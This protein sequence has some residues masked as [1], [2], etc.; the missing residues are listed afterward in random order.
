MPT[1]RTIEES[2][3]YSQQLDELGNIQYMDEALEGVVWALAKNA[4]LFPEIPNSNIR[5][6]KTREFVRKGFKIVPLKI[7]FTILSEDRILLLSI[8]R[9]DEDSLFDDEVL[10]YEEVTDDSDIPF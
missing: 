6:I 9:T 3:L 2:D 8:S 1:L 7:W 4:E 5:C 10:D